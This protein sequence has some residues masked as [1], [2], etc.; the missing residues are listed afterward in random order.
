MRNFKQSRHLIIFTFLGHFANM[1]EGRLVRNE[2][3]DREMS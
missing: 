3:S 1:V 2:N